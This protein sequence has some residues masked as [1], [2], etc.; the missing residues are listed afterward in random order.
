M[1]SISNSCRGLYSNM[2]VSDL[3]PI[4]I[5]LLINGYN[6]INIIYHMNEM[7]NIHT[8]KIIMNINHG[9]SIDCLSKKD[10]NI[11]ILI[12]TYYINLLHTFNMNYLCSLRFTH[13]FSHFLIIFLLC[14][15]FLFHYFL[16][17][18]RITTNQLI[19]N[20]IYY[21]KISETKGNIMALKK[22]IL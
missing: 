12:K 1:I 17:Y 2:R 18:V 3:R 9:S 10:H 21:L 8:K 14:I 16:L 4:C 13:L 11:C 7:W 20:Q 15:T 22:N 5:Y 19:I 6:K